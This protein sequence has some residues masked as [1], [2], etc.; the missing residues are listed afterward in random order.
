ME[1]GE[2]GG[3]LKWKEANKLRT[4]EKRC[5]KKWRVLRSLEK[6]CRELTSGGHT[7]NG[8]RPTTMDS[9]NKVSKKWGFTPTSTGATAPSL[10]QRNNLCYSKL[11]PP[12]SCGFHFSSNYSDSSWFPM[13]PPPP[14]SLAARRPEPTAE[15]ATLEGWSEP[16]QL[17]FHM[18][19]Y[20]LKAPSSYQD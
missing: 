8:M 19:L 13:S 20:K 4:A 6:S 18:S 16:P 3:G 12:A 17:T 5:L 9:Q 11:P 14:L 7:S 1:R 10:L 2:G 15:P